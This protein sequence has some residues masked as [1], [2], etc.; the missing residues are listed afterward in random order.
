M[1]T[2]MAVPIH[3]HAVGGGAPSFVLAFYSRDE[4][5]SVHDCLRFVQQAVRM[6]WSGNEM[7]SDVRINDIGEMA[8][9]VEL[10]QKFG[11]KRS[12]DAFNSM[13]GLMV[14][15]PSLSP[16][17]GG[18]DGEDWV[19]KAETSTAKNYVMRRRAR[20]SLMMQQR[21][22][23]GQSRPS[24]ITERMYGSSGVTPS[25][26]QHH[27]SEEDT[28]DSSLN[29]FSTSDSSPHKR[30]RSGSSPSS[31]SFFFAPP[32]SI[33]P[34]DATYHGQPSSSQFTNTFT[35]DPGLNLDRR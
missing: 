28:F 6:V 7:P 23:G 13:S 25:L 19:V 11:Q 35:F 32:P 16:N 2:I 27:I 29:S 26:P 17:A 31:E 9:D 14:G 24:S 15:H 22:S 8:A 18:A 21:I 3:S 33:D 34:L 5:D 10:Q 20:E 4:L 12:H 30:R 1:N